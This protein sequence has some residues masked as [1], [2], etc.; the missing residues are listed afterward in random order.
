MM[1]ARNGRQKG[2]VIRQVV[3]RLRKEY[4]PIRVI[5]FGSHA[6][7]HPDR[8]SDID[9]LIIKETKQP[10]FDRLAEARE[11]IAPVRP[12]QAFDLIVMTPKEV[13][14]RLARGDQFIEEIV[15]RGKS[16]YGGAA[17]S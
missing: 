13:K 5:L 15:T 9:L 4:R 10:F 7:G 8:D 3:E 6:W 17:A 12:G 14:R 16:V 1:S 11:V 2:R